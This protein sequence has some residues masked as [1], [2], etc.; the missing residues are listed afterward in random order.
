MP[1]LWFL[2]FVWLC[3]GFVAVKAIRGFRAGGFYIAGERVSPAMAIS[4]LV[5]FLLVNGI[6]AAIGLGFITDYTP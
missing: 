5:L 3:A 1:P 6:V 4:V 2:A